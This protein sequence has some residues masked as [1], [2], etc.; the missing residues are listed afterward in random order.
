METQFKSAAILGALICIGLTG[1]GV[2]A[3]RSAIRIKDYE[4]VVSVKGLAEREVA[5]DVAVW[6]I[7]FSGASNDLTTLYA[8]MESSSERINRFLADK[9]FSATDVTTAAPIIT[10]KLAQQYGGG[11]SA[12]RYA[13]TQ[14]ITVRSTQVDL[15][16]Q[17]MNNLAELGKTGIAFGG[18]EYESAQFL[19]TK[20]NELKPAMVEEAT[21]AAREVA[22][23]FASDSQSTLGKIRTANQGQFTVENLDSSTPHIKKVRVVSTVEYYLSD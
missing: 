14:I 3:G 18:S 21:R 5:A 12:L 10:D 11:E 17:S 4:R 6:P 19:F 2:V 23:K 8:N 13:A 16:R 7:R 22:N 1:L 20:L 9:G 15:V